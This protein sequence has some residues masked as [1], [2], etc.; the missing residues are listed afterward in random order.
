MDH[1]YAISSES[2]TIRPLR[3][4][5]IEL[6]RL[7]RNHPEVKNLFFSAHEITREQQMKW[8]ESYL[9]KHNDYMFIIEERQGDSFLRIGT[10][11]LYEVN[12][13]E[14]EFGRLLIGESSAKGKG[15]GK[16]ITH[17][18]CRIAFEQL[19]VDSVKLEVIA[20]NEI[21]ITTYIRNGF[22]IVSEM[23]KMGIK[24]L[25]MRLGSEY[26]V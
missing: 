4:D 21:A 25:E 18:T 9:T 1:N 12:E 14:A 11:A 13:Y 6:I 17:L 23:E 24:V 2:L 19:A 3:Q 10:V 15:Y 16:L 8:F 20:S 26:V 5:D 22:R 7:W